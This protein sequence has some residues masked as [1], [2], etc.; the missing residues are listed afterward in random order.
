[1]IFTNVYLEVFVDTS[2]FRILHLRNRRTKS[3]TGQVLPITP[4]WVCWN[5]NAY[6]VESVERH[7]Q[8]KREYTLHK[9]TDRTGQSTVTQGQTGN[10]N[11]AKNV[12]YSGPHVSPN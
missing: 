7:R 8:G 9:V 11:Y 2:D 4:D 10:T 3:T 6:F 1:M 12:N 5:P